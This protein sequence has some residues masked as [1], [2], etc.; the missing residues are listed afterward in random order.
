MNISWRPP[1]LGGT[2]L[3]APLLSVRREG[4]RR[5]APTCPHRSSAKRWST[6]AESAGDRPG[7]GGRRSDPSGAPRRRALHMLRQHTSVPRT[8]AHDDVWTTPPHPRPR[9]E[10]EARLAPSVSS[11][12]KR[13][14]SS[15]SPPPR[16]NARSYRGGTTCRRPGA[17]RPRLRRRARSARRRKGCRRRPGAQRPRPRRRARSARRRWQPAAAPL[18]TQARS[19]LGA[20]RRAPSAERV[21]RG[22]DQARRRR[23][24]RSAHAIG[25]ERVARGGASWHAGAAS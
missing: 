22:G 4:R 16:G 13:T 15:T 20:Q 17:Q 3:G 11:S 10:R 21:A 18:G 8:L 19:A 14:T 12:A 23:R 24:A 7:L 6:R 9:Q 25:A 5:A 2:R 1:P